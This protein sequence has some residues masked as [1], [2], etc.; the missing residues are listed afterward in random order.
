M[1]ARVLWLPQGAVEHRLTMRP[2][3][4]VASLMP[5]ARREVREIGHGPVSVDVPDLWLVCEQLQS[6]SEMRWSLLTPLRGELAPWRLANVYLDGQ[7]CWGGAGAPA[8][9]REAWQTYWASQVNRD[10]WYY[11]SKH[12]E[13]CD[14]GG[15]RHACDSSDGGCQCE[16]DHECQLSHGQHGH[17]CDEWSEYGDR[18]SPTCREQR[19]HDVERG[20]HEV[21]PET[22]H[23]LDISYTSDGEAYLVDTWGYSVVQTSR[24]ENLRTRGASVRPCDPRRPLE[25]YS[26][27]QYVAVPTGRCV[28]CD[29]DCDHEPD[30]DCCR[31]DCACQVADGCSCLDGDCDCEASCPCESGDCDCSGVCDHDIDA[32][33]SEHLATYTA[34]EKSSENESEKRRDLASVFP[35]PHARTSTASAVLVL[36]RADAYRLAWREGDGRQ[37]IAVAWGRRA[38]DGRSWECWREEGAGVRGPIR[39]IDLRSPAPELPGLDTPV[40]PWSTPQPD[41]RAARMLAPSAELLAVLPPVAPPRDWERLETLMR[42]RGRHYFPPPGTALARSYVL[43]HCDMPD[44][45]WRCLDVETGSWFYAGDG[46]SFTKQPETETLT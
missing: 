10:V 2:L 8:T 15:Q 40:Y 25:Y 36:T 45:P 42:D 1:S 23:E 19:S 32:L 16:P 7:I 4:T 43:T 24:L 39:T 20:G 12:E 30:C 37:A 28:C 27:P 6:E 34:S 13:Y 18:C 41:G 21:T 11:G 14:G 26:T 33:W 3:P 46:W 22:R 38:A 44:G 9:P 17:Q 5:G 35:A 31:G 29:G